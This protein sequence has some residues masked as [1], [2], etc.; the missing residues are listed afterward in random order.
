MKVFAMTTLNFSTMKS[1]IGFRNT[2]SAAE[3]VALVVAE[4]AEL[5]AIE[6]ST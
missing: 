3:F 1:G 6:P 2:T 5:L 4:R